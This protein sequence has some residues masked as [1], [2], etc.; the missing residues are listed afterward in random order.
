MFI[1]KYK[2]WFI[3]LSVVLVAASFAAMGVC[4]YQTQVGFTGEQR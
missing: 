4:K 2:H 3:A 1:I